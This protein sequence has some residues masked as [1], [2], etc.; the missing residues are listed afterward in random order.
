[1]SKNA[2]IGIGVLVLL[3]ILAILFTVGGPAAEAPSEETDTSDQTLRDDAAAIDAELE[4]L[5]GDRAMID[6][7][8][9]TDVSAQ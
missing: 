7:G 8:L 1:M 3:V 5:E 9:E 6:Q 2:K 4:G